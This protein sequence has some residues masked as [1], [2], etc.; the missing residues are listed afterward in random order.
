[1]KAEIDPDV[2][3][4]LRGRSLLTTHDW[5]TAELDAALAVADR[6]Q[7]LDRSGRPAALL[8][9]ELAYALFFDNSTRTKSAW[10]GAAARL[11]MQPVIVDGTSTQVSHGETAAETGAMLGMNAHALGVRHDLILGE[12]NVFMREIQRGIDDYLAATD[13]E[14]CVPIVNLQCDVD[15]PTQTLADLLWL[16]EHF[17]GDIAGKRIAV[18]WAYS[19]SYAKPLSV[20]Q[21]L[22]S[23][24]PRFGAHVTLAHPEGYDL[25]PDPLRWAHEGAVASGGTF[26]VTDDMDAAFEGADAVY[27]K[28]W[29]PQAL[30][31]ERV[32][33]NQAHDIAALHDIEE[34]A[35]ALNAKHRRW[36]CDERRMA[37]TDDALYLHCLPA[38]IGD[39]VEPSVMDRF[40][41]AV[42]EEANKKLYVIMALLAVAKVDDL[43]DRLAAA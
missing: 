7:Q 33:A 16:R 40:R 1:M 2:V 31:F 43:A 26:T 13:D 14:R 4:T 20:P 5:T 32:A 36:I 11:G 23:L 3:A 6:F 15:H 18:S 28:S 35:L 42:A 25:L 38:D 34:R 29:G 8:P 17:G 39:E 27:P 22:V 9:N 12:G 24:L 41:T 30:M 37:L 21:G 19:P 10:A